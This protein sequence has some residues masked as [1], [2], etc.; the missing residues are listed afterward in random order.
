MRISGP[1]RLV[2][3]AFLIAASLAFAGCGS[4]SEQAATAGADATA[5]G[6]EVAPASALLFASVTT[7]PGSAQWQT[8][9]A[10][11]A[12]FPSSDKVVQMLL[13]SLEKQG[14]S[15][16]ND[17]KPALGP[18][19]D[20][21]LLGVAPGE[22]SPVF[23]GLTQP[24]DGAKLEQ[25]VKSGD[26]PG[27]LET[28]DGWAV[29]S[30]K[31]ASIDAFKKAREGGVLADSQAFKDTM[32]SLPSETLASV[33]LDGSKLAQL[34]RS[35]GAGAMNL[36]LGGIAGQSGPGGFALVAQPDGLRLDGTVSGQS[37]FQIA[38]YKPELPSEV[39]AS[40]VAYFSFAN[41]SE[42][43]GKLLEAVGR[44]VPG[45]DQQLAQVESFLGL[46][47]RGDLLPL[48]SKEGAVVVAPGTPIPAISLV[49][50]VVDGEK[51]VSALDKLATLAGGLV[52]GAQP[53]ATDIQGV[54]AKEIPLGQF[55]LFYASFD[56]KLVLTSARD[57]IA[58]LRQ[59]GPKLADDPAFQA[60]KAS[61]EMP[62]D[63]G[64]FLYLDLK[65]G[66]QLIQSYAQLAG[67]TISAEADQ[68]LA[69]LESL[70]VYGAE[71]NGRSRFT[72]F[73]GV[74]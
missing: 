34:A 51:A 24:K 72:A 54:Q 73:L 6:A 7:D 30:D 70:V 64:G 8:A 66:I 11:L 9:G 21:V 41:L 50:Q 26:T 57:G 22:G 49:L 46:S 60:A 71:E 44:A 58:G 23:V 18:E 20:F 59:Q 74:K 52:G 32:A 63:V 38:S 33:F 31:Q 65:D 29:V 61:A 25:L 10:L 12:K 56:E 5:S 42:P 45:F 3:L 40:A 4:S 69:P 28:V 13:D 36:Q 15:W 43:L 68:N 19:V 53:K 2:V 17:V 27:V 1:F 14:T 47:I 39:P 37:P 67:A 62:D 48:F 55:S 16:E 35:T